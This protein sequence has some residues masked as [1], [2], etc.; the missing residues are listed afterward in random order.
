[1]ESGAKIQL[2]S[3]ETQSV[4]ARNGQKSECNFSDRIQDENTTKSET[5]VYQNK[6]RCPQLPC[7]GITCC[8][9]FLT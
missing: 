7:L 5:R 8:L 9:S 3:H 1:M 4:T 6:W 2:G